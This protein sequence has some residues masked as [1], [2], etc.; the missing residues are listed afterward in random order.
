MMADE[1]GKRRYPRIPSENAVLVKRLT[2]EQVEGFAKTRVMGLGGC[3]FVSDETLGVGAGI[4]ILISVRGRVAK[5]VGKVVYE[6]PTDDAQR[7]VGVEFLDLPQA[8]RE[9]IESLF[10]RA[11]AG[12]PAGAA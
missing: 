11:E 7:E 5:A 1:A 4:E 10:P 2:A 8:D 9:V 12:G 3:M 6:L